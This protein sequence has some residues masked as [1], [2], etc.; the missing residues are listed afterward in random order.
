MSAGNLGRAVFI[1]DA[2]D[3]PLEQGIQRAEGTVRGFAG[4]AAAT[5]KTG[6]AIS[7]ATAPFYA[8]L[9]AANQALTLLGQGVIGFNSTIDQSIDVF[10]KYRGSVEAA[11]DR[12]SELF[13]IAKTTPFDFDGILRGASVLEALGGQ[14]LAN[15]ENIRL[16]GD[17]AAATVNVT[18]DLSSS[19]ERTTFWVARF[20]SGLQSGAPLG[21]AL[22]RLQELGLVSDK[23][24]AQVQLAIDSGANPTQVFDQFLT[25]LKRFEG[26]MEL[27]QRNFQ[28]QISSTKDNFLQLASVAGRPIFDNLVEG[29]TKLNQRLGSVDT[30]KIIEGVGKDVDEASRRFISF[31]TDPANVQGMKAVALEIRDFALEVRDFFGAAK[32]TL[33][34]VVEGAAALVR[35]L[36]QLS[37]GNAGGLIA[38]ALTA[39]TFRRQLAVGLDL[40]RG[41]TSLFD[42]R[43]NAEGGRYTARETQAL[44]DRDAERAARP[45]QRQA[46]QQERAVQRAEAALKRAQ[47]R[48][49][50]VAAQDIDRDQKAQQRE[51]ARL[52]KALEKDN[53]ERLAAIDKE[54]SS[55][56]RELIRAQ[57][58]QER[59]SRKLAAAIDAESRALRALQA[60]VNAVT[61]AE[62]QWE[63]AEQDLDTTRRQLALKK[64]EIQAAG[65]E[66]ELRRRA[67]VEA[68]SERRIRQAEDRLAKATYEQATAND[69]ISAQK[70]QTAAAEALKKVQN[71]RVRVQNGSTQLLKEQAE[72]EKRLATELKAVERA[73]IGV[74]I[75]E[76]RRDSQL[77]KANVASVGV[78]VQRA[79][80]HTAGDRVLSAEANV[81]DLEQARI[82]EVNRGL[83]ARASFAQNAANSQ[84]ILANS[85]QR[86]TATSVAQARA[87][88]LVQ[89][90][91]KKLADEQAALADK[92]A[93]A[94]A[95]ADRHAARGLNL[96]RAITGIGIAIIGVNLAVERMTGESLPQAIA[97]LI[98]FG[99][100]AEAQFERYRKAQNP[101]ASQDD[102]QQQLDE[103]KKRRDELIVEVQ[104]SGFDKDL[105]DRT[106]EDFKNYLAGVVSN[107]NPF[108]GKKLADDLALQL[109]IV[110]DLEEAYARAGKALGTYTDAQYIEIRQEEERRRKGQGTFI[111]P[112]PVLPDRPGV[113]I[114][115][116]A[117][118][119]S[120]RQKFLAEAG[121][122]LPKEITDRLTGAAANYQ[123]AGRKGMAAYFDGFDKEAA[124]RFGDLRSL[125]EDG[126][127]SARPDN[128]LTTPDLI[129]LAAMDQILANAMREIRQTGKVTEETLQLINS[130]G[131]PATTQM[132]DLV[133]AFEDLD[134]AMERVKVTSA[135][136]EQSQKNL[137]EI[138]KKN[139]SVT[140]ELDS[141]IEQARQKAQD[142]AEK[143]QTFI[144]GLQRNLEDVQRA[145]RDAQAELQKDVTAAQ[146][147]LERVRKAADAEAK[148][149]QD[150]IEKQQ[151]VVNKAQ[152]AATQHAAAYQAVLEGNSQ[153]FLD[154]QGEV[155]DLTRRIIA[156][157]EAEIGA[158]RRLKDATAEK[159]TGLE[160]GQRKELLAFDEAIAAAR[161][162]GDRAEV[163][164]LSRLRG[165]AEQRGSR[166]IELERA[167]AA[168]AQDDFDVR[169][170]RI[171]KERQAQEDADNRVVR[172]EQ[173]K[174]EIIQAQAKE[175]ADNREK[176]IAALQE[177]LDTAQEIYRQRQ[178]A[179]KAH[180]QILSDTIA[181]ESR[182]AEDRKLEDDRQLKELEKRHNVTKA[183]LTL[184]EAVSTSINDRNKDALDFANKNLEAQQKIVDQLKIQ[185]DLL[186]DQVN[187]WQKIIE[188]LQ[189]AGLLPVLTGPPPAPNDGNTPVSREQ[190]PT[191]TAAFRVDPGTVTVRP[192]EVAFNAPSYQAPDASA[193]AAGAWTYNQ[194][195]PLGTFYVREEADIPKIA[196]E[197]NRQ[198]MR[199]LA[200]SRDKGLPRRDVA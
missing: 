190:G 54:V 40:A 68:E 36:D 140:R 168:V 179:D 187:G 180:E 124:D 94:A 11:T 95:A 55:A 102:I 41:R 121:L 50:A 172:A 12:V 127:K 99:S 115:A 87:N 62:Q 29:L 131:G 65:G 191:S 147:A 196:A 93:A 110:N 143:D 98:Q 152:T 159:A 118:N 23:F 81:K 69:Y 132:L 90:Q 3:S 164:R 59:Q 109:K 48:A 144:R 146:N 56:Q 194:N 167:R 137:Q 123:I 70:N 134:Y 136:Y 61:R 192:P 200:N 104:K 142:R 122:N 177:Q 79:N 45:L 91:T 181:D 22:L 82:D 18:G 161:E 89:Q 169:A 46:E 52:G 130:R 103:A 165:Q 60:E 119:E 184:A 154:Q 138:Q 57:A 31:V 160:R 126:L 106:G 19:L 66:G 150:R 39:I 74:A 158:F 153:R 174:L 37:A 128:K 101:K 186:G 170:E 1:L 199:A 6:L 43:R 28:T 97:D 20:Y 17:A 16:F 176:E 188:V 32:D 77:G 117:Q 80:L 157:Y 116:P 58:D 155:D 133:H 67:A 141:I 113:D 14:W 49:A 195:A 185:N 100:V 10:T 135:A 105:G 182:A 64:A 35:L 7:F 129:D 42:Q 145:N 78:G 111:G 151:E 108:Y 183:A 197:I 114:N 125:M 88:A 92:Q 24:R 83:A 33:T 193:T 166:Q 76:E 84:N 73:M 148:A 4:R 9:L 162:R 86:N 175:A 163:A 75:A 47:E 171:N 26:L 71:D 53:K 178:E 51:T 149:D 8:T 44:D 30:K 25:N 198:Q 5:L 2:D 15:A 107:V 27:Q 21:E 96:S 189:Q 112:L 38:T 63:R 85:S 34:P 72:L 173:T 13:E 139:A 120:E 156:R